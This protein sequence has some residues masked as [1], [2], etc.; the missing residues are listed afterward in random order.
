MDAHFYSVDVEGSDF[1]DLSVIIEKFTELHSA[2]GKP[3]GDAL[4]SQMEAL[5]YETCAR[6]DIQYISLLNNV[7][8]FLPSD[9]DPDYAKEMILNQESEY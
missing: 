3:D 5:M 4:D 7:Y 1:P 8:V 2:R 9:M 6:F